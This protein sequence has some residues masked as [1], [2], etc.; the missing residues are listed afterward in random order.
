AHGTSPLTAADRD[1]AVLAAGLLLV[2]VLVLAAAAGR[3]GASR[4]EQRLAALR[5]AGATPVQVL[6]MTGLEATAVGATGATA[7]TATYLVLLPLL[8]HLPFG[9][10]TWY[11]AQLWVGPL[12]LAAVPALTALLS[13]ASA[14]TALRPVVRSPWGVAQQA[15]PHRTR[16]LR[17]VLFAALIGYIATDAHGQLA[18]RQVFGLLLLFYTAFWIVGPWVVDR[19]GRVLARLARRPATLLAARRL[20]DDPRGAWR[21]VSGLV[22]AGFVAGFFTIGHISLAGPRYPDQVALLLPDNATAL[23]V[24]ADRARDRLHTARVPATVTPSTPSTPSTS[25]SSLLQGQTG[26]LV[27]V[28]GGPAEQDRAVTALTGLVPGRTPYTQALLTAGDDAAVGALGQLGLGVLALGFLLA[29]ASAGLTTAATVLDRRRTYR[30]LH[31]AGTPLQVLHRARIRE[32]LI[33]LLVLAGAT[34]SAGV[35]LALKYTAT[36]H[37]GLD[38]AATVRL[39]ACLLIGVTTMLAAVTASRPVLRAVATDPLHQAD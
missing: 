25:D 18:T 35:Y 32:T 21:T 20:S 15:D 24:A 17:L 31:L 6:T 27:R 26:I 11:P 13:T 30:L 37:T 10:G 3:L 36:A 29:A 19:L 34:T 22:L 9:I 8:A 7:G 38:R 39:A 14:V 5:L 1:L 16:L 33:P 23:R 28:S 4:R 12:W 2:P